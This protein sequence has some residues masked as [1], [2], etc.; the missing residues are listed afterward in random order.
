MASGI[1]DPDIFIQIRFVECGKFGPRIIKHSLGPVGTE[2]S[3]K[4]EVIVHDAQVV[5]LKIHV[6]ASAMAKSEGVA[7]LVH[8]G[9]GLL[10]ERAAVAVAEH[11]KEVGARIAARHAAG[12]SGARIGRARRADLLLGA[13]AARLRPN[14]ITIAE[15]SIMKNR[16]PHGRPEM[17]RLDCIN[18]T[19]NV[20]RVILAEDFLKGDLARRGARAPGITGYRIHDAGW[21]QVHVQIYSRL[22]VGIRDRRDRKGVGHHLDGPERWLESNRRPRR[23]G[24]HPIGV[25]EN[26][27]VQWISPHPRQVD[28]DTA[29]GVADGNDAVRVHSDPEPLPVIG[30]A[31]VVEI[32]PSQE[33]VGRSLIDV[34]FGI[35]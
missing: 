15:E 20:V 28:K 24:S 12:G 4:L 2:Q 14:G 10:E 26:V 8:E 22:A 19:P 11:D 30:Q 35:I 21:P 18:I 3:G 17:Q 1:I 34:T 33:N 5:R 23:I 7:Q 27:F 31:I 9:A 6:I 16:A 29:T 32:M 25:N 13:R